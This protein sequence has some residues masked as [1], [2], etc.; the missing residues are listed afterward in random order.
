MAESAWQE[1]TASA[2][3]QSAPAAESV[4][5]APP[6]EWQ[7]LRGLLLR[8]EQDKLAEFAERFDDPQRHAEE[9]SEI[10]PKAIRLRSEKDNRL[11]KALQPTF[12]E[13]LRVSIKKDPKPFIDAVT[14][15]MGAAIRKAIAE[16]LSAMM[17]SLNK[18]LDNSVSLQSIRWRLEAARTGKPFA[19]VVMLHT[20]EYRVEQ[21]F[22]IHRET[23]LLLQH[24]VADDDQDGIQD[25]DMVSGMLTAIQDFVRDSFNA[26]TS[27]TLEAM[28]VGELTVWIEQGT[29]ATLAGVIRGA[30]PQDL[31]PIF[32]DALDSIH[33]DFHDPLNNFQGDAEPFAEC[34]PYLQSC[35]QA[36]YH[37]GGKKSGLISPP[38]AAVLGVGLLALGLLGFFYVR[39]YWRWSNY[40]N[41]L[42]KEPGLVVVKAEHGFF[43]SAIEGLR[44]PLAADPNALLQQTAIKPA[45]VEA[46]WDEYQAL[47]PRF[48]EQR[49]RRLLEPPGTV[50]L[51]VENGT[52]YAQGAASPEWV[53]EARK[54]ARGLAGV[55]QFAYAG[56][57]QADLKML[58]SSFI[59]FA[60]G[61]AEM[62]PEAL[63][64]IQRIAQLWPGIAAQAPGCR[65]EL[66][67]YSD[68]LGSTQINETLSRQRAENTR[69]ALVKAGLP[70]EQ[71]VIKNDVPDQVAG[72]LR[73]DA[74]R[75]K[76]SFRFLAN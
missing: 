36:R 69:D 45:N 14:P 54:L 16:A 33:L 4:S 65:L 23:G 17:Q 32:Q 67:G 9:V 44:D 1:K 38:V 66:T 18:T 64:Q 47:H 5:A 57:L 22:L 50:Q 58:E 62:T 75:R 11:A 39:S 49:A 46:R 42:Q 61:R 24:A 26:Q 56:D 60:L 2:P 13:T 37:S 30:A 48:I 31:R 73:E 63:P 8:P 70:A 72:R 59:L 12:E 20:L 28:K 40:V 29:Q 21:V 76:V 27:E 7:D 15:V 55:N 25:A 35:L 51:K 34:Q 52:L 41:D 19:E 74:N 3:E 71:L 53:G 68:A 43:G 10:L 6:D